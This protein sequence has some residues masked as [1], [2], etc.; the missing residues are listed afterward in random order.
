MFALYVAI[1]VFLASILPL[2]LDQPLNVYPVFAV[3]VIF[4]PS[5]N[6]TTFEFAVYVVPFIAGISLNDTFPHAVIFLF[7]TNVFKYIFNG[8]DVPNVPLLL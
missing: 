1:I 6:V 4:L 2:V 8:F 7:T 3:A 5:L